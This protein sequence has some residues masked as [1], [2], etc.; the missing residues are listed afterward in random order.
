MVR[1]GF[2]WIGMVNFDENFTMHEIISVAHPV[3][4]AGK[5]RKRLHVSGMCLNCFVMTLGIIKK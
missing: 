3:Q 5:R 1:G 2:T 4:L